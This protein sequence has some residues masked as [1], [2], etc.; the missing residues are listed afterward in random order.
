MSRPPSYL[1]PHSPSFDA[2]K[3]PV[4]VLVKHL[5]A[6]KQ[7]L[8]SMA[9]VVR[10]HDLATLAREMY[11]ECVILCAQTAFLRRGIDGQ[12][13]LLRKVRRQLGQTYDESKRQFKRLIR[14]L[15]DANARLEQTLALLRLTKVDPMF[16]PPGEEQ[17]S[18]LDFIDEQKVE[19]LREGI[20]RSLDEMQVRW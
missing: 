15:D 13:R 6:A 18:L 4:E 10:A 14:G 20:K 9:L 12:L 8:S 7:S 1:D 11:E 16:R 19:G 17:K 5:L 3:V 2:D